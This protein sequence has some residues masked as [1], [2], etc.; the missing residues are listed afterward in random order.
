VVVQFQK[1]R[2]K[3]QSTLTATKFW[4]LT[5]PEDKKQKEN[6]TPES[7]TTSSNHLFFFDDQLMMVNIATLRYSYFQGYFFYE[8][9]RLF[10]LRIFNHF[11]YF[12]TERMSVMFI[13]VGKTLTIFVI[14]LCFEILSEN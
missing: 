13:I 4:C 9:L 2:K 6:E 10:L 11:E 1:R 8:Y 3:N 5:A 7:Y 12:K 14:F